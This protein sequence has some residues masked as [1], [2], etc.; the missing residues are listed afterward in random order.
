MF[1]FRCLTWGFFLAYLS[2]GEF[3]FGKP[4]RRSQTA[5]N[6]PKHKA[7]PVSC[8]Q[9]LEFNDR[10]QCGLFEVPLDYHNVSAGTG[11]IYYARLPADEGVRKGTIFVD[12]GFQFATGVWRGSSP[13]TWLFE[14]GEVLHD[15]TGG[16]YDIVVWDARGKGTPLD[17]L[18]VP[19]PVTCF[20]NTTE[21]NEFYDRAAAELGFA[22]EWDYN[23]EYRHM[24]GD[25]D[26]EQWYAVQKKVVE[27]CLGRTDTSML[28]YMGT[29]ASARDLAA[30]AD[31]FDGPGSLI[32]FW[33]IGH[34]S[35]IGSYLLQIFPERAGR[36]LLDNPVDPE[37]YSEEDPYLTWRR[38]VQW[39]N[40][41]FARFAQGC[42]EDHD[43]GCRMAHNRDP[44]DVLDWTAWAIDAAVAESRAA[45][46]GWRQQQIV[47]VG[48]HHYRSL[49]EAVYGH[50]GLDGGPFTER[51]LKFQSRL[52]G[53][54]DYLDLGPMP[55]FCGD[56]NLMPNSETMLARGRKMPGD[57]ITSKADAPILL[58]TAF[59]S[60]QYMCHL[61]PVRAVE[62]WSG[63][64][65]AEH[66]R[67]VNPVLVL[68]NDLNPLSHPQY[69]ES[70]LRGLR[71]LNEEYREDAAI[72]FQTQFGIP[73]FGHG[74][75]VSDVISAYLRNGTMPARNRCY[76]NGISDDGSVLAHK[77]QTEH[78]PAA[79]RQRL[80]TQ[81][82]SSISLCSWRAVEPL[83][84]GQK[85][86][87][88]RPVLFYAKAI[89][90][91]HPSEPQDL[92]LLEG[93]IVGV[94]RIRKDG[95]AIGEPIDEARRQPRK[96]LFPSN[97]VCVLWK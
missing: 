1:T 58:Q 86:N 6:V 29:A 46:G 65:A 75:C 69:S 20:T 35:L 41:T 40:K 59:P 74:R 36:V 30:M 17:T 68:G 22:A 15:S 70:V 60:L 13:R 63:L 96:Y 81:P 3:A 49:L 71:G 83:P 47:D 38:D 55:I 27:H 95:W 91:F 8:L 51:H 93:D 90:P 14:R 28:P 2:I 67:P 72:V 89:F 10:Y 18:T 92:E 32:N 88:G 24:Q 43:T 25:K 26:I 42:T 50:D 39:A 52:A 7:Q 23:L 45:F 78:S 77:N 85:T 82:Y 48:N 9:P 33:G 5:F 19:G 56:L 73:T 54:L 94:A 11:Q 84:S 62:R 64:V 79:V 21:R 57:L 31:A 37:T 80:Q 53:E 44:E 34:G 66:K 12:P 4:A 97:F 87:H 76:G 16:E 61:W